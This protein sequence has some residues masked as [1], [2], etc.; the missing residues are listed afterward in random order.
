MLETIYEY[1]AERLQESGEANELRRRQAEYLLAVTRETSPDLDRGSKPALD[2]IE[3]ELDNIRAS[4]RWALDDGNVPLGLDLAGELGSFWIHRDHEPEARRWFEEALLSAADLPDAIRA[5]G[6]ASLG[7]QCMHTGDAKRATDLYTQ[8]LALYQSLGQEA[9]IAAVSERL[10][11]AAHSVGEFE[12]ARA[13]LQE[14]LAIAERIDD[15]VSASPRFTIWGKSNVTA[16][17]RDAHASCWRQPRRARE[18]SAIRPGSPPSCTASGISTS[19]TVTSSAPGRHT[20]RALR[21]PSPLTPIG[22]PCTA[23]EGWRRL[24]PL[25]AV[26]TGPDGF[27]ERSSTL[28]VSSASRS[29]PANDNATS[30]RSAR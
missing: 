16:G 14:S 6:L 4:L 26:A 23:S 7:E 2:R 15:P 12:L 20:A 29:T 3:A 5:R 25:K 24:R 11:D 8:A 10:G 27:G 28:K 1:A 13:L 21:R 22:Q 18:S 9:S 17:T 19:T 30:A